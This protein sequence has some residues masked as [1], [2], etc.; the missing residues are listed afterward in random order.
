MMMIRNILSTKSND[1][2]LEQIQNHNDISTICTHWGKERYIHDFG[3][4]T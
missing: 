4:E 2:L 3:G 1:K